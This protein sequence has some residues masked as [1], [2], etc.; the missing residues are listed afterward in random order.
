MK[1]VVDA[2]LFASGLIKPNSN[3]GK[4]LDLVKQDKI[5]LIL[6]PAIIKEIKRILLYPKIQKYHRKTAQE[7]DAYFDDIFMFAWIVEGE[8]RVDVIIDDPAD[9]KYLTCAY[10]GEADYI[11]SGDHHLLDLKTYQGIKIINAGTF[12]SIWK[13]RA[14]TRNN[15]SPEFNHK[16]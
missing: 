14:K 6:S 5:E 13:K 15:S 16:K 7:I 8:E 12:L 10:E 9:N 2:N 11:V 4:I 3:P 1:I